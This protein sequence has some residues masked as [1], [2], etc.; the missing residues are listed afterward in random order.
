MLIH[1]RKIFNCSVYF[2]CRY[3][4]T[5]WLLNE[6]SE[7]NWDQVTFRNSTFEKIT[8]AVTKVLLIQMFFLTVGY[9]KIKMKT[10]NTMA[11]LYHSKVGSLKARESHFSFVWIMEFDITSSSLCKVQ[12]FPITL[13]I[14]SVDEEL[15]VPL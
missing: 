2:K 6:N 1:A 10:Q 9:E 5:S 4:C 3:Q 12:V 7:Q 14:I 15:K 11:P 8:I 13:T